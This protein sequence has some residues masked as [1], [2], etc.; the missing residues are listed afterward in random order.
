MTRLTRTPRLAPTRQLARATRQMVGAG[1]P[2]RPDRGHP[3]RRVS[4]AR[5]PRRG[6]GQPRL[7]RPPLRG[8]RARPR[9][10]AG[11][12]EVGPLNAPTSTR[13]RAISTSSSGS[14]PPGD[15]ATRRSRLGRRCAS[16]HRSRRAPPRGVASRFSTKTCSPRS[17]ARPAIDPWRN[18][19][20]PMWTISTAG[21]SSSA[22]R[23]HRGQPDPAGRF[24]RPRTVGVHRRDHSGVRQ[25]LE[26]VDAER[27]ESAGA[28]KPDA[29]LSAH[30]ASPSMLTSCHERAASSSGRSQP[31]RP[32]RWNVRGAGVGL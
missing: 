27:P 6:A 17:A 28:D 16:P 15:G 13:A 7:I 10:R 4:A 2:R 18:G 11:L 9:C 12:G 1:P 5:H 20:I 25:I 23:S 29:E 31:R 30:G 32:T 14:A 8:R 26:R 21:S 3:R 24:R 19:D 22:S